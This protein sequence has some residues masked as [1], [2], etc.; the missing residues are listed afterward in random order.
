ML[1]NIIPSSSEKLIIDVLNKSSL[2]YTLRIVGGWVKD[3]L[4][5]FISRDIDLIIDCETMD[6]LFLITNNT[7]NLLKTKYSPKILEN[8]N[9]FRQ[10]YEIRNYGF[11]KMTLYGVEIDMEIMA[12]NRK[13]TPPYVSH[14]N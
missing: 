8:Q 7:F 10:P 4:L 9:I 2:N 13:I 6:K 1:K 5:N 14:K 3:K 11:L 12:E